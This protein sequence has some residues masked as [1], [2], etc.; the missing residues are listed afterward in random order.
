LIA[1]LGAGAFERVKEAIESLDF[2]RGALLLH[3]MHDAAQP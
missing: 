3:R 1:L 2:E